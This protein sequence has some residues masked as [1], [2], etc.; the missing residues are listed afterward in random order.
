MTDK[1]ELEEAAE[2]FAEREHDTI[3]GGKGLV[4]PAATRAIYEAGGV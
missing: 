3:F 1:S 2:N 4:H